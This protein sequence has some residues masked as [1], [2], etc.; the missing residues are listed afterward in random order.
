MEYGLDEYFS[1]YLEKIHWLE[2]ASKNQFY[3]LY[4]VYA[5]SEN[6]ILPISHI[7]SRSQEN[8]Y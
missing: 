8:R 1:D 5:F 6:Y 2:V 4:R 3:V 7:R